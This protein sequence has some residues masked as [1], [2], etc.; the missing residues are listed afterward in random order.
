MD[1]ENSSQLYAELDKFLPLVP[2][3]NNFTSEWLKQEYFSVP[4][5]RDQGK[6]SYR[7]EYR[8]IKL[9]IE[10]RT[11]VLLKN[12]DKLALFVTAGRII[13]GIENSLKETYNERAQAK[14]VNAKLEKLLNIPL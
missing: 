14:F 3:G 5:M 11:K 9:L 2:P 4:S 12:K 7:N 10:S 13:R 8:I 6:P 1:D